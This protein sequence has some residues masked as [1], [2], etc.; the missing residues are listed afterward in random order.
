MKIDMLLNK[1]TKPTIF[2]S[3]GRR[4]RFMPFLGGISR[5][6]SFVWDLNL[7][8]WFYFQNLINSPLPKKKKSKHNLDL[9]QVCKFG[10]SSKDWTLVS[11]ELGD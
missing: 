5:K 10:D 2:P 3:Q 9:A 4:D 11:L 6:Y 1:E 7:G 8:G